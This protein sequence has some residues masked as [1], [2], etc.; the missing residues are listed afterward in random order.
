MRTSILLRKL[1]G[2]MRLNRRGFLA[3]WLTFVIGLIF[4]NATYPGGGNF[5][6]S[7]GRFWDQT[8]LADLWF[9]LESA[10]VDVVEAVRAVE[11]VRAASGRLALDLGLEPGSVAPVV[12]VRL[13]SLPDS[14]AD[15]NNMVIVEGQRPAA[16]DEI[17]LTQSFAQA[18]G[19]ALGDTL[20][21][22]GG[23]DGETWSVRVA[24]FAASGEYLIGSCAP[25]RPGGWTCSARYPTYPA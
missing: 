19:I 9:D 18:Q 21:L 8:H 5:V 13:I 7:V 15:V 20:N 11:G 4:Y 3:V 24:G 14:E 2:D 1:I 17:A 22:V 16:R 23:A 12:T 6:A 25:T 10:P